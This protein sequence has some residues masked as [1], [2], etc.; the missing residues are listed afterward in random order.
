[1]H[2]ERL[3]I[4]LDTEE[5]TEYL[6]KNVE[7]INFP[8]NTEKIKINL[9]KG[10]QGMDS[11]LFRFATSRIIGGQRISFEARDALE[12]YPFFW[13]SGREPNV[14]SSE[15]CNRLIDVIFTC[16]IF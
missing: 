15:L 13:K 2:P 11:D 7:K 6:M 4:W 8:Q 14:F 1:M 9:L 16:C 5:G 12:I 10:Y 3:I